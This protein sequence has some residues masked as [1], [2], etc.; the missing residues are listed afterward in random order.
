MSRVQAPPLAPMSFS[1]LAAMTTQLGVHEHAEMREPRTEHGYCT[2]DVARTLTVVVREPEH[3]AAL[4]RLASIYLGFLEQAVS[5]SG[6]VHNRMSSHGVWIDEAGTGDWWGRAVAGLGATVRYAR[7]PGHRARALRMFLR[8]SNRSSVDVRASAFAAAGAADVLQAQPDATAA[9]MLLI[10]CLARI[11]RV[12][13]E[14]FGWPEPTLRYA[15]AAL[16]DALIVGGHALGRQATVNEGL[17][18]LEGLLAV[19][20]SAQ[21]HLS[22]T[23]SNG[24]ARDETGPLWDQQPI[25]PAAIADACAHALEIT[26]ERRW[27]DG[28]LRAWAWFDGENDNGIR[29]FDES[30]GAGFDGLMPDGHNANCGAE[31]TIAAIRTNQNAR[32]AGRWMS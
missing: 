15:N 6:E 20:T 22:V 4:D 2:D 12:D 16:C 19:E 5:K 25:E 3:S 27:A 7:D 1:H 30:V 24:R 17:R 23:G 9:R 14:G 26:G 28:V 8:A 31:S 18:M 21:G 13:D 11:P 32:M 10:E 29:M